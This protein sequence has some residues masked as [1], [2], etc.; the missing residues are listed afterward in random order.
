MRVWR[1]YWDNIDTTLTPPGTQYGATRSKPEKRKR[2]RYADMQPCANPGNIYL[3]LV[4]SS[5]CTTISYSSALSIW[6]GW[7]LF[8]KD[9]SAPFC[10]AFSEVVIISEEV[11]PR[12]MEPLPSG[13]PTT[14]QTVTYPRKLYGPLF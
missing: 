2:L 4:S 7:E 8:R 6:L 9:E 5:R 3:S 11:D 13:E 14:S 10:V 12:S 1:G